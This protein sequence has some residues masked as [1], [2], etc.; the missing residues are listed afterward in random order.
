S[1][2]LNSAVALYVV[3]YS[4]GGT[5]MMLAGIAD[6]ALRALA[7][8]VGGARLKKISELIYSA[9]A[10]TRKAVVSAALDQPGA[11]TGRTLMADAD[12]LLPRRSFSGTC[13]LPRPS[14]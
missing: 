4:K 2:S 6:S 10:D 8:D 13:G 9:T 1:S 11:V 5:A 3:T 14:L 7:T 12:L